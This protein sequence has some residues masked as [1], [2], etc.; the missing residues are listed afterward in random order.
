M[1]DA[2]K[3][4]KKMGRLGSLK[5]DETTLRIDNRRRYTPLGRRIYS[6]ERPSDI[7]R[8]CRD[9]EIEMKEFRKKSKKKTIKTLLGRIE[10]KEPASY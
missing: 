3:I 4:A 5:F 10:V 1:R 6:G 7:I 2:M 9:A 8:R